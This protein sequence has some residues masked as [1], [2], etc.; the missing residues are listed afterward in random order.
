MAQTKTIGFYIS[1]NCALRFPNHKNAQ[2]ITR[3]ECSL[4]AQISVK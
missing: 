4:S 1:E 3:T 2:L